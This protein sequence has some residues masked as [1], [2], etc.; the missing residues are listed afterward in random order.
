MLSEWLEF[1][2][3]T[4][5]RRS[6]H[7]LGKVYEDGLGTS[8]DSSQATVWYLRAAEQGFAPAQSA[9]GRRLSGE[10]ADRAPDHVQALKWSRLAANQGDAARTELAAWLHEEAEITGYRGNIV[11]EK[12]SDSDSK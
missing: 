1:R 7:R 5:T 9:M 6:Q 12:L 4:I 10:A 2:Q 11:P 8:V 3:N